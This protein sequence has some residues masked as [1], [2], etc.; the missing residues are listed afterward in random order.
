[1]NHNRACYVTDRASKF[2]IIISSSGG[3]GGVVV[4][5]GSGSDIRKFMLN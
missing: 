5:S 4:A 1:M 3:G 2:I